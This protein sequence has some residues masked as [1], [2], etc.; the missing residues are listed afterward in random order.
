MVQGIGAHVVPEN[1]GGPGCCRRGMNCCC[2]SPRTRAASLPGLGQGALEERYGQFEELKKPVTYIR[3]G[4]GSW[5]TCVL[6]PGMEPTNNLGEQAMREHVI[7][8]KIIG[9]FRSENGAANY[10]YIA[11][12]LAS[13]RLQN[14]NMFEELEMLIRREL[15][16]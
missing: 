2:A 15:C 7:I 3:N 14:K 1:D 11:S 4:L 5:Y 12:L 9:C 6:H 8:R 13:W 10:Q 16:L